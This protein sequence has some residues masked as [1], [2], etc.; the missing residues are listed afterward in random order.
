MTDFVNFIDDCNRFRRYLRSNLEALKTFREKWCCGDG[1]LPCDADRAEMGEN[2]TLAMRHVEDAAMRI[3]KAIQAFNGG[4]SIYDKQPPAPPAKSPW[5]PGA[6]VPIL[7]RPPV[8][9]TKPV[10]KP[11]ATESG[12]VANGLT[13]GDVAASL[14][15]D[16]QERNR[17]RAKDAADEV[18]LTQAKA[19]L[20]AA[21][22]GDTGYCN[23]NICRVWR[24]I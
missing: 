19:A 22:H 18:K 16:W 14:L 24:D 17:V 23:C 6:M 1:R 8:D 11:P 20:A 10:T 3:G 15:K 2:L 12:S 7:L 4:I 5:Q 21:K 9:N 13:I